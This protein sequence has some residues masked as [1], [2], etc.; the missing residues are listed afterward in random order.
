[1]IF[2]HPGELFRSTKLVEREQNRFLTTK[3][4]LSRWK[5][6]KSRL[7]PIQKILNR[8]FRKT[9]GKMPIFSFFVLPIIFLILIRFWQNRYGSKALNES[10]SSVPVSAKSGEFVKCFA[11]NFPNINPILTKPA[12][13]ESPRSGLS[14]RTGFVK[15]GAILRRLWPKQKWKVSANLPADFYGLQTVWNLARNVRS[16]KNK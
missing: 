3:N 1:M 6:N 11:H 12:P 2:F 14:I 4:S 8:Y 9:F 7:V 16:F 5:I 13:I 15:I 10:F